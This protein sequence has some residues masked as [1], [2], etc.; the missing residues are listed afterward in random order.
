VG[1]YLEHSRVYRFGHAGEDAVYYMGSADLMQRNLNMRVE[2]VTP[3]IDPRIKLRLEE[4]LQT[5]MDDDELAW[6]MEPDGRSWAR[7]T[8]DTGLNAHRR[9][10]EL[11]VQRAAGSPTE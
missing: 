5:L 1:K 2:A 7:V 11:A 10:E 4:M 8:P 9:L 3:I 6:E